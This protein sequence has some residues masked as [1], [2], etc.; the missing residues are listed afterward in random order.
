MFM[1][2]PKTTFFQLYLSKVMMSKVTI[3]YV[4][5]DKTNDA[6]SITLE[7]YLMHFDYYY[8]LN[9]SDRYLLLPFLH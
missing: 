7:L 4:P 9:M 1:E 5:P 8:K 2:G 3:Y 6:A